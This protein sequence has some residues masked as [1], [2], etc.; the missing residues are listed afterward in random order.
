MQGRSSDLAR[1]AI[2]SLRKQRILITLT[3]SQPRR[4]TTPNDGQRFPSAPVA[5]SSHWVPPPSRSPNNHVRHPMGPPKHY[6]PVPTSV[7]VLQAPA[8]RPQLAPAP[9]GMQPIFVPAAAV[10]PAMPFAA[11]PV[12]LPPASSGGWAAAPPPRHPPPPRPPV[13]GTGVFLPPGSGNS[14]TQ[15]PPLA[16][17]GFSI[18]TENIA[19]SPKGNI[20]GKNTGQEGNGNMDETGGGQAGTEEQ[21]KVLA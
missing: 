16:N 19:A 15:P 10:A 6:V 9:N 4:T 7:G 13:C 2:P 5:P 11:A 3:K 17:E 20:D 21:Q 14:P 1:H 8:G 12:A 18:G